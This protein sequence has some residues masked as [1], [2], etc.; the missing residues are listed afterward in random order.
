MFGLDR[1]PKWSPTLLWVTLAKLTWMLQE[2]KN[3]KLVP[4]EVNSCPKIADVEK[5]SDNPCLKYQASP[6]INFIRKQN[7]NC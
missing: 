3:L 1:L 4:I 2:L 6:S 7:K 5:I